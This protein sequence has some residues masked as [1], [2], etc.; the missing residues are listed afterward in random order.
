ML[1]G[2]L[3]ELSCLTWEAMKIETKPSKTP[4]ANREQHFRKVEKTIYTLENA[5]RYSERNIVATSETVETVENVRK[6]FS[7]HFGKA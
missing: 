3:L 1:L 5:S 2:A 4:P 6:R 7:Q